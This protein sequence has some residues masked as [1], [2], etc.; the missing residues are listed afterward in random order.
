MP[1]CKALTKAGAPCRAQAGVNGLCYLHARPE[2]ARLLGQVGGRK[3]RQQLP[4]PPTGPFTLTD[5]RNTLANTIRGV[6][7]KTITPRA[8]GAIAQL[9]NSMKSMLVADELEDRVARLEQQLAEQPRASADPSEAE[10]EGNTVADEEA[11]EQ[12]V[13]EEPSTLPDAGQPVE[14]SENGV[15][16]RGYGIADEE[17]D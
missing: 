8:A 5:L 2:R 17:E 3:N 6:E 11:A 10:T 12:L 16:D 15:E 13:E 4:E 1:N 7:S 9:S 14:G